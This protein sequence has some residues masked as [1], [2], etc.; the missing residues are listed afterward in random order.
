MFVQALE[1]IM[2]DRARFKWESWASF[3]SVS[4]SVYCIIY[5]VY[6]MLGTL[7]K[8]LFF[9]ATTGYPYFSRYMLV[10]VV[11]LANCI[12]CCGN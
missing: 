12:V 1:I 3:S 8:N 4:Y 10:Q 7:I 9:K 6:V 2:F 5:T 11:K